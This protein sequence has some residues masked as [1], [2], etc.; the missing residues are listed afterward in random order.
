MIFLTI[1]G[2]VQPG[3]RIPAFRRTL[4]KTYN[5]I[6]V[7]A[8][9]SFCPM[10]IIPLAFTT[11]LKRFIKNMNMAMQHVSASIKLFV[12]LKKRD[13]LMKIVEAL[14]EK[15]E[16]Y[17]NYETFRPMEIVTDEMGRKKIIDCVWAVSGFFVGTLALIESFLTLFVNHEKYER[18]YIKDGFK[19]ITVFEYTQPLPYI[20]VVPWNYKSSHILFA[21]TIIYQWY[22]LVIFAFIIIG[23]DSMFTSIA[24]YSSAQLKVL[25]GAFKT[26]R[27]RSLQKLGLRDVPVMHDSPVLAKEMDRQINNCID[28]LQ[29]IFW[30]I[31]ELESIFSILTLIQVL[32][33]LIIFCTSLFLV[34]EVPLA[35]G[36]FVVELNYMLAITWQ[37]YQYC[38]F[39]NKV[40]LMGHELP[41]A[42]YDGDWY[43]SDKN[44][45]KKMLISM[46]RMMK[47]VHFT[48]GKFTTLTLTTFV[49]IARGSYSFFTLLKN[50]DQHDQ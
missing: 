34:T 22:P 18:Y 36:K 35:S 2:V 48:I 45:K 37:I 8:C 29:T 23:F 12:W 39:G 20:S 49:S 38:Y 44:F 30:T 16:K 7:F 3:N 50:K 31:E 21:C 43:S 4:W 24:N 40:T 41:F 27:P 32:I 47:P 13:K 28:H 15:M 9:L 11:N 46:Q 5:V 17:E 19:N 33:S 1:G 6:A 42:V 26:I 14:G 25:Q 10:E